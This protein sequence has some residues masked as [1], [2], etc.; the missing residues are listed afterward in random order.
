M[1]PCDRLITH[2]ERVME[3]GSIEAIWSLH[4]D[5]M[6]EYLEDKFILSFKP[7]P[8]VLA[9]PTFDHEAVRQGLREALDTTRGCVVEVI[10]KDNHTIGHCPENVVQW[11][12]IAKEEAE[13][14]SA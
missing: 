8:A 9:T 11:C 12:Q 4:L 5:K 14:S 7:N 10:M 3:A 13:R 2:L 1:T 6:A